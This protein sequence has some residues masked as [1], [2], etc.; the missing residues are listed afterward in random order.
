MCDSLQIDWLVEAV[1]YPC[2]PESAP[3]RAVPNIGQRSTWL[4]NFL[5]AD[6]PF[7][8]QWAMSPYRECMALEGP[9]GQWVPLEQLHE[10]RFVGELFEDDL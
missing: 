4:A 5:I 9:A 1:Y 3:P 2:H 10:L 7:V 8:G 6:G